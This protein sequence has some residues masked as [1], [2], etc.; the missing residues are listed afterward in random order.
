MEQYAL[1]KHRSASRL[2]DIYLNQEYYEKARKY[3]RLF[4]KK[5]K[6]KHFGGNE[7]MA[8]EIY[9]ARQYARLYHGEGKT[10]KAINKLLPYLFYNGL[11]SNSKLL[12]LLDTL[13]RQQYTEAEIRQLVLQAKESMQIR[14]EDEVYIRFLGSKVRVWSY[15]LFVFNSRDFEENMRL[16][17]RAKWIKAFNSHELFSR[18]LD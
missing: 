14:K 11:A 3:I 2:A 5:Y 6:Y 10:A 16:E 8:H 4:D 7:M 18:Y 1:Y 13:L 12:K 15:H 17:G 9:T